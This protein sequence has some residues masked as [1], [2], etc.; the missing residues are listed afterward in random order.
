VSGIDGVKWVMIVFVMAEIIPFI[1]PYI[2]LVFHMWN[3]VL[4][5]KLVNYR[6]NKALLCGSIEYVCGSVFIYKYKPSATQWRGNGL[7]SRQDNGFNDAII[8]L[9]AASKISNICL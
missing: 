1:G 9:H 5:L 3:Y 7:K 6:Q 8:C 4:L 2:N